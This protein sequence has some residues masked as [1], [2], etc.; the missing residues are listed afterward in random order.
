MLFYILKRLGQSVIVIFGVT[1]IVFAMLFISGDPVSLLLPLDASEADRVA[2]R[3]SMGFDDPFLIQYGRFLMNAL[4]GDL[5]VSLRHQVPAL[6]LIEQMLPNSIVL[7]GSAM[8]IA[9]SVAIPAGMIAAIKR[10]SVFDTAVTL[11]VLIGQAMPVFWLGLIL[12]LVFSVNLGLFPTGGLGG[13]NHLVLPAVTLGAFS[14]SRI[15]RLTRSGLL[16]VMG[17]DYIRTAKSLGLSNVQ[18]VA[19]YA[20]K[21]TAIPLVT[22]IGM[23]FG[24]LLGGAIVTESIFSWPGLGRLVVNA[25]NDRDYALVQAIV[26]VLSVLFVF[27]NL[28][29][30]IIYTW[31][32][33]RVRL[34]RKE[35]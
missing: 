1:L 28:M 9:V 7:V 22:L 4:Q 26:T 35:G 6:D 21:N 29:V 11:M 19:K 16:E 31:L 32:D 33:P 2:M 34:I 18:V 25:I 30:D 10:N 20:L 3:H 27:I 24:T 5:G 13:L 23:E 17:Q 12:I 8:L 14:M 15:A